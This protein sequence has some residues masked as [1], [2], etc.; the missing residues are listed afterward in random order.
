MKKWN[1]VLASAVL[2]GSLV[3]PVFAQDAQDSNTATATVKGEAGE[4]SVTVAVVGKAITVV[5]DNEADTV[6]SD[7]EAEASSEQET[8]STSKVTGSIVIIGP[9]GQKTEYKIGKEMPEGLRLLLSPEYNGAAGGQISIFGT[10]SI[11]VQNDGSPEENKKSRSISIISSDDAEEAPQERLMIGVHCEEGSELLRGHLKLNGAGLVVLETVSDAPAAAAGLQKNDIILKVG[12]TE[13]KA[14]TDLLDVVT[15]SEGKDLAISIMRNGDPMSLTVTPKMMEVPEQVVFSIAGE[16]LDYV[17][18][19]AGLEAIIEKENLPAHVQELMKN[20]PGMKRLR[21]LQPGSVMI[22]RKAAP[23][24]I[25]RML[26]AAAA[27]ADEVQQEQSVVEFRAS[28]NQDQGDVQKQL[29][30]LREQL[31]AMKA[32]I[33]ELSKQN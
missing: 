10:G 22:D 29:E 25:E 1:V 8:E 2:A 21:L 28:K 18:D 11:E 9:D 30:E 23:E 17:P 20:S 7:D 26:K 27:A 6:V 12:E 31:K 5:S 32:Q 16:D 4:E 14:V 13:M 24:E 19:T 33:D 3:N 15:K